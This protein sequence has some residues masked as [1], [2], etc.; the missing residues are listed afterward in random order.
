[1][2]KNKTKN[3]RPY[4]E[5]LAAEVEADF[6]ARR[7]ERRRLERQ[8]ELNL[9]FLAGR[10]YM[11]VSARGELVE[12]GKAFFWQNRG[13]FNH[14]APIVELRLAKLG[15]INPVLT[16]RAQGGGDDE[17]SGAK[18]SEKLL[19]ALADRLE[20][21]KLTAEATA[22]SET[23]GTAFY[24]VTWDGCADEARV[25]VVSPF[26]IYPDNLGADGLEEVKSLICA[27]VA[28]AGEVC[29]TY[30]KRVAGG[31]VEVFSA[32]GKAV[33]KNAVTLI[34]RYERPCG[35]FPDGRLLIAAA[36][37]LLYAGDLPY[38]NGE[39]GARDFPFV[40]Q[41]SMETTGSFFAQSVIERLIP[42]QRAFNAVKNRKHEFL[43]RLSMGVMNVEDGSLDAEELAE[44]GLSPGKI[45]V[46]RQGAKPP[47]ML[48]MAGIPADFK[49]EEQN[50]L[51]E[52]TV[53]SGVSDV[54]SS[55]A[56]ATV[57]SGTA[58]EILIEQDNERM[59]VVAERIRTA[60]R[61]VAV[62]LMRLYKQF[63]AGVKAVRDGTETGK[64]SVEYVAGAEISDDVAIENENELLYGETKKKQMLLEMYES[65]ILTDADGNL[66]AETKEKVLSLLGYGE[67]AGDRGLSSLHSQKAKSENAALAR[68]ELSV[69]GYDDHKIHA[70]E[71]IRYVLGEDGSLDAR[72]KSNF[73]KHIAEHKKRLQGAGGNK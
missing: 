36:G 6:L 31:E 26:E 7:E 37:V 52:F 62:Q 3:R 10:Q 2:K 13:V 28:D 32:G 11:D 49:E 69:D 46:Y 20:L 14:I 25:S 12:D 67:L 40:R 60:Y 55:S 66:R 73:E 9:N 43:N 22:W 42:V 58:L 68:T 41:A 44:D 34:E 50:L 39:N 16:V 8:W 71:H 54:A 57:S 33:A 1:M 47:E 5:E 23:C 53:I 4:A 38:V 61:K 15:K 24:K 65:G 17:V 19:R 59:T 70:E 64:I 51:N 35:E 27:R 45:L 72:A 56:N 18:R 48:D 63:V 30:K 21:K 29:E